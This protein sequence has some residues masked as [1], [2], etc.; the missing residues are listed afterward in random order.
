[1]EAYQIQQ[2]ID[3]FLFNFHQNVIMPLEEFKQELND[4]YEAGAAE[5]ERQKRRKT[6]EEILLRLKV[7]NLIYFGGVRIPFKRIAEDWWSLAKVIRGDID[8]RALLETDKNLRQE[9]LQLTSSIQNN[10][11][12]IERAAESLFR[13]YPSGDDDQIQK[14]KEN[15]LFHL[16]EAQKVVSSIREYVERVTSAG[17]EQPKAPDSVYAE[18]EQQPVSPVKRAILAIRSLMQRISPTRGGGEEASA[19]DENSKVT[20]G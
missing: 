12:D 20:P 5:A 10:L 2:Q 6:A 15:I 11:E 17:E 4:I 19:G 18:E 16:D 13:F 14:V 3:D 7:I 1:M 9:V 8:W